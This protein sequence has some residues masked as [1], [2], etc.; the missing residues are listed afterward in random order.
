[1]AETATDALII[2]GAFCNVNG[3]R[4]FLHNKCDP[5]ARIPQT[6]GLE[7]RASRSQSA[8]G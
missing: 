2:D 3:D 5:S 6:N 1:M 7:R 4:A 8:R